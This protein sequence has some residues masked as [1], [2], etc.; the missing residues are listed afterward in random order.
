[1]LTL[2]GKGALIV[3]TRRVGGIVAR[4]LAAE[5]VSQAILYRRSRDEA[6]RLAADVAP[7]VAH[8]HLVQA[9]MS[10]EADVERAVAEAAEAL[11][12]LHFLVNM[13]SDFQRVPFAKLDAEAWERAMTAAKGAYLLSVHAA[14]QMLRNDGPTRGHIISFGDWAAGETVY[15]DYLPYLTA[16]AAV[17]FMTRAFAVELA[18]HGV[19]V[20]AIA[21]G[22]T[23]RPTDL[24]PEEWDRLVVSETPLRRESSADEIAEVVVTLLKAETITGEI[25]RVDSGRHLAGPGA[26][27]SGGQSTP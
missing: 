17:H 23:M 1:M 3:G 10:V 2:D 26:N 11:G 12:G 13:A 27:T 25:I 5:G 6:E 18:G 9:D 19:L 24:P 4:R 22:P 15:G 16:K 7:S 20:N 8:V 21:P 14:R